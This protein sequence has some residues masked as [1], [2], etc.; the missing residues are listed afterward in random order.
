M[1]W[2]DDLWLNESF[3]SWLRA[4]NAKLTC[5]IP[6]LKW[7]EQQG[8]WSKSVAMEADAQPSTHP[9]QQHITDELQAANAFDSITY[10]KGEAVLRMFEAYLG[11]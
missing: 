8:M 10:Q 3:A 1:G 11:P 6:G 2:W 4:A 7:A 5:E 9:I